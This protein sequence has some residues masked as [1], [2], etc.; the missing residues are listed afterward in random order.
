[1]THSV[2]FRIRRIM[3]VS[4][5]VPQTKHRIVHP[6]K[7]CIGLSSGVWKAREGCLAIMVEHPFLTLQCKNSRVLQSKYSLVSPSGTCQTL[8][9]KNGKAILT[10]QCT[11]GRNMNQVA[12]SPR[13]NT[14]MRGLQMLVIRLMMDICLTIIGFLVLTQL[15]WTLFVIGKNCFIVDLGVT[16]REWYGEVISFLL[17]NSDNKSHGRVSRLSCN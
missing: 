2:M 3:R 9:L 10:Q 5:A 17:G 7:P 11:R 4:K 1:M 8:A 13:K 16:I 15:F 14:A 12:T 6:A